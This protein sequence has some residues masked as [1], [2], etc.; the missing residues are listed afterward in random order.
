MPKVR[1]QLVYDNECPVC[2]NYVQFV[3]IRQSVGELVLINAREDHDAV[4]KLTA[5]G[6][7]LDEGMALIMEERVY[8]GPDAVHMLALLG[9]RSGIFNRLNYWAFSSPALSKILYPMLKS[10]RHLLLKILGRSRIDN[11]NLD[12]NTTSERQ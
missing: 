3:R 10:G 12:N 5:K 8:Y 7:D 4:R 9:T 11:L 1:L 6:F 2:R